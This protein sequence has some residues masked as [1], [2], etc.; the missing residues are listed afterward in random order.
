MQPISTRRLCSKEKIPG[1]AGSR[2]IKKDE[3]EDFFV[4][5]ACGGKDFIV[6]YNFSLRFHGVNF[7]EDLIYDE[8]TYEN[9]KCTNCQKSF[10]S[11]QIREGLTRIKN[12][13]RKRNA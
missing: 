6:V 9:F 13:R 1:Y 8:L 7:S 10:N 2:A 5:D 12:M 4:C 11:R 3:V